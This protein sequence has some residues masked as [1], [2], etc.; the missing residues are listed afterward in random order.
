[1]ILNLPK[2]AL[3]LLELLKI[4][5]NGDLI[6]SN[7]TVAPHFA[8]ALDMKYIFVI[9][10]GKYYGWFCPYPKEIS[11]NYHAICH[12]GINKNWYDYKKLSKSYGF[13]KNQNINEIS[14]DAVKREL[15]SVLN[16]V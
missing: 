8:V 2:V 12:P 13:L 16:K 11:K 4:I 10:S 6:F 7:E 14:F 15:D 5:Y 3:G 1:M 9:F